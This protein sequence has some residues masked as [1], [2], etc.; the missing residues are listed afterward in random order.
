MS[1][2]IRHKVFLAERTIDEYGS[3]QPKHERLIKADNS[4]IKLINKQ[5]LFMYF[6]VS[7]GLYV[8]LQTIELRVELMH[9]YVLCC[10]IIVVCRLKEE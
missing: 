10:A 5:L 2:K 4:L 3:I 9:N 8:L 7:L 6:D 1:W